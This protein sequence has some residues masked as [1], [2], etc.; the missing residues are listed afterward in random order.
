MVG[1]LYSRDDPRRDAGFS[2][3]Y[4][5]INLGA[6]LGPILTGLLQQHWGFHWGFALAAVGMAIG[7]IQ[8]SFGRKDLPR[9]GIASCRTRCPAT[10]R[11]IVIG[12][13]DRACSSSSWCSC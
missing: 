4:L 9:R 7:L 12:V 11:G 2:L 8:Y 13:G 1:T 5:G 10:A 3:F 6:F